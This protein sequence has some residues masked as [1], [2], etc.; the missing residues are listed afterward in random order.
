MK[1]S[2]SR[3]ALVL[4][5]AAVG[6]PLSAAPAAA[7]ANRAETRV[8]GTQ[9]ELNRADQRLLRKISAGNAYVVHISQQAG[10]R[11]ES[12]QIRSFAASLATDH[13]R[14]RRELESMADRRGL[15]LTAD[16]KH[17]D[18]AADLAEKTGRDY[19]KAWIEDIIDAHEDAL[20][21]LEKASKSKD[22]DVAA[23]GVQ[24]IPAMRD[25][26][27]RARQLKKLAD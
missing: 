14:L 10:T 6:A 3:I 2:T 9:P 17:R 23:F 13:V 5:L 24:Y 20:D 1:T 19:D 16:G 27:E 7:A 8:E 22:T 11:A 4:A 26:L 21:V 15:V 18:D 25:Y 12:G